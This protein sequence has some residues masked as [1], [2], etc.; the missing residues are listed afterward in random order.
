MVTKKNIKELSPVQKFRNSR[1]KL[2]KNWKLDVR[3]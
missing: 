3:R 1:H 2:T